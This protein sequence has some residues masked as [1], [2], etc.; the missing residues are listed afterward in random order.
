MT[1]TLSRAAP[2]PQQQQRR[3]R[4]QNGPWNGDKAD[5]RAVA[6]LMK[7]RVENEELPSSGIS[8][9]WHMEMGRVIKQLGLPK[10]KELW[11]MK[12]Y[13]PNFR[14]YETK[15]R[16]YARSAA[17]GVSIVRSKL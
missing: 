1:A 11:A 7:L 6:R 2:P 5:S 16:L 12:E 9:A 13:W 17:V 14:A 8:F 15:E 4:R 10:A 3:P